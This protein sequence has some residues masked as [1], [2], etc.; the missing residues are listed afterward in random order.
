MHRLFC[1]KKSDRTAPSAPED[2]V[3]GE[4][5]NM[6]FR[7]ILSLVFLIP[8]FYISMGHM[9]G[10]PLPSFLTGHANALTFAFTQFLLI[11]PIVFVNFKYFQ[12]GFKTLFK[13]SPNM[14]SLIAIGSAAA[15]VYGIFAIYQIGIVLGHQNMEQVHQYTMDLYFESA[16]MILTLITL[17]KYLETRAK[18]KTSEAITKL[19]NL[20]PKTALVIR[21]GEELEIPSEEVV[22]GD[23]IVIKPGK[24]IPVDGIIV[25]GQ[26]AVDEAAITGES[27]PV[28][29]GAGDTVIGAT[30]NK[31]GYFRMKATKV[32]EDSAFIFRLFAWWKKPVPLKLRLPSWLTG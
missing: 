13:G 4:L 19:M 12:V 22:L 29:K 30:V 6:K 2:A 14:D 24:T 7:L 25:E 15:I 17:G 5:K 28:E 1:R 26:T 3:A 18:G 27:V 11:L 8:L 20:A 10:V 23:I 31:A 9:M 16:G 32:G 21:E